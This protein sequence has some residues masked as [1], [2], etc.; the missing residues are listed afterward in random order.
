MKQFVEIDGSTETG[1]NLI[2]LLKD[3]SE[4]NNEIKFRNLNDIEEE[5]D[6]NLAQRIEDGL[7]S[8]DVSKENIMRTLRE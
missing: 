1:K 4:K 3:L 8:E 5:L 7:K 6:D 2:K